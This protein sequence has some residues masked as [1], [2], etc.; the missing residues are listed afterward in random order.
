MSL[1]AIGDRHYISRITKKQ[2]EEYRK[3][4]K[5]YKEIRP[6]IYALSFSVSTVL[7]IIS[8]YSCILQK[9]KGLV[10]Y[11]VGIIIFMAFM[12]FLFTRINKILKYDEYEKKRKERKLEETDK[13][14]TENLVTIEESN[15]LR[16]EYE[17]GKKIY[18]DIQS[19]GFKEAMM[20]AAKEF[21]RLLRILFRKRRTLLAGLNTDKE[22][23]KAIEFLI[24]SNTLKNASNEYPPLRHILKRLNL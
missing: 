11:H 2:M 10:A 3:L 4:M 14:K 15:L 21:Y 16:F 19:L 12:V 7:I 1:T 9:N 22:T 23:R 13:R 24:S 6:K 5:K 18:N 8:L 20:D 17:I